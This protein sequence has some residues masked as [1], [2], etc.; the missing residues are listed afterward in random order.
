MNTIPTDYKEPWIPASDYCQVLRSQEMDSIKQLKYEIIYSQKPCTSTAQ[1]CIES[2]E[3]AR[4]AF[5]MIQVV[6]ADEGGTLFSPLGKELPQH[7]EQCFLL[8]KGEEM[9]IVPACF[10]VDDDGQKVFINRAVID[11]YVYAD[12]H[13]I[14]AWS[15]CYPSLDQYRQG[16]KANN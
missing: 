7:D 16:L 8:L 1:E 15:Y 9:K 6:R 12:D 13:P 2:I 10:L 14:L 3:A 11:V 4:K 5:R